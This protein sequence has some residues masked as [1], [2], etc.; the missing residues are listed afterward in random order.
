MKNPN[1]YNEV[2]DA[3]Y[4]MKMMEDVFGHRIT[5]WSPEDTLRLKN[6]VM[7]P[8]D[9]KEKEVYVAIVEPLMNR[10]S[11]VPKKKDAFLDSFVDLTTRVSPED[12]EHSDDDDLKRVEK[13][14]G[15]DLT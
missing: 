4:V 2:Q 3:N 5:S 12:F 1:T 7:Q 13:N 11:Y 9:D 6:K 10:K 8:I 14:L 15:V